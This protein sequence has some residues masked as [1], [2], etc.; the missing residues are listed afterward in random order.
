MYVCMY[1]CMYIYM[2]VCMYECMYVCIGPSA[3]VLLAPPL[4]G[5]PHRVLA[6]DCSLLQFFV[7]TSGF[8]R[9]DPP[10]NALHDHGSR[11]IF[12]PHGS[13]GTGL[14]GPRASS[15]SCC[16]CDTA[17]DGGVAKLTPPPPPDLWFC[18]PPDILH[19]LQRIRWSRGVWSVLR[20]L[21]CVGPA[22][23]VVL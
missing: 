14:R 6:R 22:K 8:S 13:G 10:C 9:V 5:C 11:D 19:S 3:F 20:L 21:C 15:A 1:V 16:S 12:A 17:Q 18:K 2:Y 4:P 7:F 23:D